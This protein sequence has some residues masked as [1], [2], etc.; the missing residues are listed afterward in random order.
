MQSE[1]QRS[2]RDEFKAAAGWILFIARSLAV[3]VELFLHRGFGDRYLGLPAAAGVPL[4]LVFPIFWH[5][6]DVGPLF[7]FLFAYMAMFLIERGR[8]LARFVRGGSCEHTYY[9]GRPWALSVWR[10]LDET[11][12]KCLWEPLLVLLL[13]ALIMD[14]SQPLGGYLMLASAGLMV[15]ANATRAQTHARVLDMHDAW[16]DQRNVMDELRGMRRE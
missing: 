16:I 13:G 9:S 10:R 1:P 4:I 2:R 8:Q 11:K 7:G 6:H 12:V 15:S 14:F 3:S 5:G